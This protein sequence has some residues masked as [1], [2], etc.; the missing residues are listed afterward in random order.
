MCIYKCNSCGVHPQIFDDLA[1][2]MRINP[3]DVVQKHYL[4]EGG[5]G[6]VYLATVKLQVLNVCTYPL[7]VCPTLFPPPL[8]GG[9]TKQVAI[10]TFA[11]P[12]GKPSKEEIAWHHY[13]S[14]NAEGRI[15]ASLHHPNILPLIGIVFQPIRLLLEF[16]PLGSLKNIVNRYYENDSSINKFIL[17]KVICQVSIYQRC[18]MIT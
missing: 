16:A 2:N 1:L 7:L 14:A 5:F 12:D 9:E 10:K 18:D 8:Q 11:Q 4:D 6:S 15:M 17:Q 3:E 13:Q